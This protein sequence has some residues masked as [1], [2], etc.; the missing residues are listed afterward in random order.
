MYE[1]SFVVDKFLT[2]NTL[3]VHENERDVRKVHANF[4]KKFSERRNVRLMY[5]DVF[6]ILNICRLRVL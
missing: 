1:G 5:T 2:S 6:I 3:L 4:V